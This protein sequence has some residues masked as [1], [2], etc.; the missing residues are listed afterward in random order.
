MVKDDLYI[1]V[2]T[3]FRC[4]ISLDVM[5]SPVSLCTGVTYDR[6][7][8]Q[9]WLDGGNNT[10]PATM[11]VLHNKDLIPNHTLQRL[12][13]IWSDSVLTRHSDS[14]PPHSLSSDQARDL[15]RQLENDLQDFKKSSLFCSSVVVTNLSRLV[16]FAGEAEENGRFLGRLVA[17]FCRCWWLVLGK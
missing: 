3:Y 13:K 12:I 16:L 5:K 17:G 9:R 15:L 7:S 4:P 2:P 1:T 8:I 10:C 6:S 14:P 11:Q